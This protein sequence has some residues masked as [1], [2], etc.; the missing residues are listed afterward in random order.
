MIAKPSLVAGRAVVRKFH[1]RID[2]LGD[3]RHIMDLN[4]AIYPIT[5]SMFMWRIFGAILPLIIWMLFVFLMVMGKLPL[6]VHG[7]TFNTMLTEMPLLK[8]IN[9]IPRYRDYSTAKIDYGFCNT[10]VSFFVFEC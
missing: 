8:V 4:I 2:K 5:N 1:H 10:F 3:Y 6:C 9:C 7:D